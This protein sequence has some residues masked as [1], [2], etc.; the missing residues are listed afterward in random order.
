MKNMYLIGLSLVVAG[1]VVGCGSSG[2]DG[3]STSADLAE[4]ATVEDAKK[5]AGAINQI[6]TL[7]S[8]GSEVANNSY[9]P[10]RSLA[11]GSIPTSSYD[12]SNSGSFSYGGS[13][14]DDG[15]N[16]DIKM[17]YNNCDNGAGPVNG[18]LELESSQSG[19]NI[20][21]S[22]DMNNYSMSNSYGSYKMDF[23]V[24]MSTNQNYNPLEMEYDGEISFI[25]SQYYFNVGYDDFKTYIEN[26]YIS[27]NG[28]V[29]MDSNLD[30][31]MN[32]SYTIK[33]LDPLYVDSNGYGAGSISVNGAVYTYSGNNVQITLADGSTSTVSQSEL[34]NSCNN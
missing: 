28:T 9:A 22:M 21:I 7:G 12:C 3:G 33:T 2:G 1:L 25:T 14:S 34:A 24:D 18:S 16:T 30:S 5:A 20:N 4:I 27:M 15:T 32:G 23:E 17:T 31:C 19:N 26:D 13:Y 6:N 29:S 11:R 10:S 8:K